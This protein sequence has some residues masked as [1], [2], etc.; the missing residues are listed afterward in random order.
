MLALLSFYLPATTLAQNNTVSPIAV[1][2][3]AHARTAT[4]LYILGGK[5]KLSAY[6][7]FF[8]LDLAVPWQGSQAAWGKLPDGIAQ[9]I[10][11]MAASMDEKELVVFHA[12]QGS[13]SLLTARLFNLVT[14]QW[15]TSQFSAQYAAF[16]GNGAVTDPSTGLV[17]I[18]G[19]YTD[20]SRG[21]LNIYTFESDSMKTLTI[22]PDQLINRG[23]YTNAWSKRLSSALYFGGYNASLQPVLGPDANVVTRY[24]PSTGQWSRL[25]CLIQLSFAI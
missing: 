14:Q 16:Q 11:P 1:R 8:S 5:D 2:G 25:V 9:D 12:G 3:A 13:S 24:S 22:P 21:S 20:A 18:A 15:S 10:F 19:S 6:P 7:Q 23:Y 4:K 17:Y